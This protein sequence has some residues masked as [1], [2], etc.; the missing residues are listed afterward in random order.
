MKKFYIGASQDACSI[1][2]PKRELVFLTPG[3]GR[4]GMG[5]TMPWFPSTDE[6]FNLVLCE[7]LSQESICCSKFVQT[8]RLVSSRTTRNFSET[9]AGLLGLSAVSMT[10]NKG[11]GNMS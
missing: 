7:V 8:S 4:D 5:L 10:T 6:G 1:T 11:Y 9:A 2:F 3:M